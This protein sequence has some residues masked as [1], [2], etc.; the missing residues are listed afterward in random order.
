VLLS[1]EMFFT[2]PAMGAI[3]SLP[4]NWDPPFMQP[5][6]ARGRCRAALSTSRCHLVRPTFGRGGDA[7]GC[8]RQSLLLG[9]LL[10]WDGSLSRARWVLWSEI[11]HQ[12][13]SYSDVVMVA[14]GCPARVRTWAS[15]L[16][17]DARPLSLWASLVL[18]NG[19]IRG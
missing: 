7:F 8:G 5:W 12:S 11:G 3:S 18:L 10:G 19:G 14:P 9:C 4:N 6:H 15:L 16:G 1:D 13:A 17:V 2:A